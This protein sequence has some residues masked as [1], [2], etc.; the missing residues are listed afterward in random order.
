M[1]F[2]VS[3]YLLLGIDLAESGVFRSKKGK[4]AG[5]VRGEP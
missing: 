1:Y 2:Y 5:S 4:K 3:L